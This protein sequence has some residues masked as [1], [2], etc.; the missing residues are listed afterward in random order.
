MPSATW[1]YSSKDGPPPTPVIDFDGT[2]EEARARFS[3]DGPLPHVDDPDEWS[4]RLRETRQ[5]DRAAR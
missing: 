5:R 4:R 3:I 1:N 2:L